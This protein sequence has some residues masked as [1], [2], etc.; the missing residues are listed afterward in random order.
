VNQQHESQEPDVNYV[1]RSGQVDSFVLEA[2]P[3]SVALA[4][5]MLAARSHLKESQG[6]ELT[7]K[8]LRGTRGGADARLGRILLYSIVGNLRN[9]DDSLLAKQLGY[10]SVTPLLK[11]VEQAGTQQADDGL[12]S[13]IDD[14][15]S[16]YRTIMTLYQQ[17]E[18]PA[19]DSR[20]KHDESEAPAPEPAVRPQR[21][22][23]PDRDKLTVIRAL[24]ERSKQGE[25]RAY[26]ALYNHYHEPVIHNVLEELERDRQPDMPAWIDDEAD[27]IFQQLLAAVDFSRIEDIQKA[28]RE[29]LK[30][31]LIDLLMYGGPESSDRV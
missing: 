12:R 3:Q 6:I 15:R 19:A 16:R 28:L 4:G 10:K 29:G 8:D 2:L 21:E 22:A 7:E 26:E 23:P 20:H 13:R 27:E 25:E 18:Q 17:S 1:E 30:S 31:G 24:T 9:T 14:V 11:G 5:A